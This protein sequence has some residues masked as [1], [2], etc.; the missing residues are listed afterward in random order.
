[1]KKLLIIV[2]LLLGLNFLVP[3]G[4]DVAD[5]LDNGP[6]SVIKGGEVKL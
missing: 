2:L 5:D 1:M 4:I 6:M 3:G